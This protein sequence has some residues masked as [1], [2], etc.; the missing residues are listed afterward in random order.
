M[1]PLCGPLTVELSM[2]QPAVDILLF[3]ANNPGMDTAKDICTYRHLK[4]A[5]VSFHVDN[6]VR[7]GYLERREVPG[8]PAKMPPGMYGKGRPGDPAG[9]GGT[10]GIF[11]AADGGSDDGGAGDLFPLPCG[12]RRKYDPADRPPEHT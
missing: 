1:P 8:G 2:A 4:P 10:G 9:L 3:L 11:P 5:I 7:E 12:I 6:L